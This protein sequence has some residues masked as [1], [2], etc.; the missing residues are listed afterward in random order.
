MKKRGITENNKE[1]IYNSIQNMTLADLSTFFNDN[2]K[3]GTYD[4]MVVG[5][6]NDVDINALEKLGKV[7]EFDVDYLFNYETPMP[8]KD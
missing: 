8:I 4:V 2:I 7:Q 1:E 3:N 5:N 6:K